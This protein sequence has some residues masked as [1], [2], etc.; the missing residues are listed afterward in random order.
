M[1]YIV[2]LGPLT[3][4]INSSLTLG[5][6]PDKWKLSEVIPLHKDAWRSRDTV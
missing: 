2:I 3:N 1:I 6:F 5:K 4:L